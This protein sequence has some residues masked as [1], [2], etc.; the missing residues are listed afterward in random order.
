VVDEI[1]PRERLLL[2]LV[3]TSAAGRTYLAYF[4]E[5]PN[6]DTLEGLRLLRDCYVAG[7]ELP[8]FE[9][10]V[11]SLQ[12]L[13]DEGYIEAWRNVRDRNGE[14]AKEVP[15]DNLRGW[16][17]DLRESFPI[18]RMDP[19]ETFVTITSEGEAEARQLTDR[20][21]GAAGHSVTIEFVKRY[22]SD[23]IQELPFQPVVPFYLPDEIEPIPF[24]LIHPE[25]NGLTIEYPGD[26]NNPIYVDESILEFAEEERDS[27]SEVAY[28]DRIGNVSA[29]VRER[30]LSPEW[31]ELSMSWKSGAVS[32]RLSCHRKA[33]QPPEDLKDA[34][35]EALALNPKPAVVDDELRHEARRIAES[36]AD[37][38]E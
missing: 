11:S 5:L 31:A 4:D 15:V 10:S 1:G 30:Q 36:I 21:E 18:G 24:I 33:S 29:T 9:D 3:S 37:Q 6:E 16:R 2:Y 20:L 22:V 17:I 13:L 27:F 14:V 23:R 19:W 8:P 26:G 7:A 32:Y 25:K 34:A 28:V 38:I 35:D 12:L